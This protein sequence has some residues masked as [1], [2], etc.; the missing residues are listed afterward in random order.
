VGTKLVA[1]RDFTWNDRFNAPAVAIVNETFARRILGGADKVGSFFRNGPLVQVVGIVE[2][3]KYQGLAEEARP[4][5]F[6]PILQHPDASV[7]ALARTMRPEQQVATEM[8]RVIQDLDPRLPVYSTASLHELLSFTFLPVRA[9]V[10]SLGTFGALALMV[11]VIGIYGVAAYSVSRRQREIGIRVALRRASLSS[12]APDFRAYGGIRCNRLLSGFSSRRGC[13]AFALEH[14]LPGNAARSGSDNRRCSHD[15]DCRNRRCL[16]S[17]PARADALS[18]RST[19]S[20]LK[21]LAFAAVVSSRSFDLI[22]GAVVVIIIA[23]RATSD[24]RW[25]IY[26][27]ATP[28]MNAFAD[29]G[30]RQYSSFVRVEFTGRGEGPAAAGRAAHSGA[31]GIGGGGQ[32]AK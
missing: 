11:S 28:Q 4:A 20:G 13:G 3:G 27:P 22:R 18:I 32:D 31:L 5:L 2:D 16:S 1:G 6:V 10:I 24:G 12:S 26:G 21:S 25:A 14:R 19:A 23:R 8:R 17:G 29:G 7:I 9:A 30:R 15:G